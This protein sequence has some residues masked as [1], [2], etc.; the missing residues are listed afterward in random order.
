LIVGDIGTV[1]EPESANG[2]VKVQFDGDPPLVG[3]VEPQKLE[4]LE[5]NIFAAGDCV[6]SRFGL[7]HW[8]EKVPC[9]QG[10]LGVA[11]T[12]GIQWRYF[13]LFDDRLQ[14]FVGC[15]EYDRGE[16]PSGQ[17]MFKDLIHYSVSS[18]TIT[19][20]IL[21]GEEEKDAPTAIITT[22]TR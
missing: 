9:H 7:S 15:K 21:S 18:N 14:S 8:P 16:K 3:T 6:R 19:V 4:K 12:D 1:L 13:V 5:A 17:V 11:K 20:L 10:T 22:R 2:K